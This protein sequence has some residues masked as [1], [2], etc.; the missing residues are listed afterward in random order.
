MNLS[1]EEKE[2]ENARIIIIIILKDAEK[3]F[4]RMLR[5][6]DGAETESEEEREFLQPIQSSGDIIHGQRSLEELLRQLECR[7]GIIEQFYDLLAAL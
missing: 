4:R 5:M 3:T 6:Q 7:K 2:G 1:Q